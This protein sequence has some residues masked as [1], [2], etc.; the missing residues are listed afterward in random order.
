MDLRKSREPI[1]RIGL[2]NAVPNSN[3]STLRDLGV[4]Y[5]QDN[6]ALHL[7]DMET[8]G[9]QRFIPKGFELGTTLS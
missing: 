3:L 5:L 1:D 6:V 8:L 9:K 4:L 7:N 2:L